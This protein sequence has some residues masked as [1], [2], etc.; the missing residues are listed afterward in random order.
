MREDQRLD[1]AQWG[2]SGRSAA[3]KQ[4]AGGR[5]KGIAMNN[6]HGHHHVEAGILMKGLKELGFDLQML[7][8]IPV[9]QTALSE[10]GACRMSYDT[11]VDIVEKL[12]IFNPKIKTDGP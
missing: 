3:R 1:K 10:Y 12:A 5:R 6:I 9:F 4:F 2:E 8:S 7:S 11:L